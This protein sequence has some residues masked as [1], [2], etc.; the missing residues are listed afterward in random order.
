MGLLEQEVSQELADEVIRKVHKALAGK[1]LDDEAAVR[2]AI[3]REL[4]ALIP[5][6]TTARLEPTSDGGPRVMAFV[7]PTG[8]GKTTTVAKL[9]AVF[10][11]KQKKRVGL[12][13]L[14][15]YRIAAVDQ[16]KTYANIIG[17]P[18]RVVST[19]PEVVEALNHFRGLKCDVVLIDTAGEHPGGTPGAV[20]G[21]A[22]ALGPGAPGHRPGEPGKIF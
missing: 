20:A 18:L 9:A 5:T 19:P 7:G 13:T 16:L 14:D 11:L 10:K 6:G 15:T 8:V 17:V 1:D 3:R 21:G 22:A 12:I 4:A 2:K